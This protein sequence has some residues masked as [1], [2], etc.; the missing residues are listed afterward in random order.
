MDQAGSGEDDP[1][2]GRRPELSSRLEELKTQ[3]GWREEGERAGLEDEGCN[4]L[5]L[6]QIILFFFLIEK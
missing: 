4:R 3:A 2:A 5:P 1:Q 6:I